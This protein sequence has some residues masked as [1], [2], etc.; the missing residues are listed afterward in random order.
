MQLPHLM[1]RRHHYTVVCKLE[2]RRA[3]PK[4][5]ARRR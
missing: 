4:P 3:K 5:A 2:R 1:G